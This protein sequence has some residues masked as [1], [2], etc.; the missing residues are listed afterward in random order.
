MGYLVLADIHA[1]LQALDAVLAAAPEYDAVLF[2]GDLVGYGPNPNEVAERLLALPNLTA[3]L[4]NH[5]L[6][7]LGAIDLSTFNPVAR[8]AAEWT[9]RQLSPESREYLAALS[10]RLDLTDV[11][12]AHGSPRD[13]VWEYL[14]DLDEAEPNFAA[15]TA[16]LALVGHTHVPRTF[17]VT[18]GAI[19]LPPSNAGAVLNTA[20]GRAI[21]NPGGVGQP[22][23]GDPRA[24]FGI[25]D[26]DEETFRFERVPYDVGETQERMLEAGLPPSLAARLSYGL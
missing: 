2:L 23:D 18:D 21:V 11:T 8:F 4:G 25:L 1:N 26:T 24:A 5:D 14:V 6:A 15:F 19:T 3:L 17:L 12:L 20:S 7:A 16:P 22:R 10:P 9:A 13:P